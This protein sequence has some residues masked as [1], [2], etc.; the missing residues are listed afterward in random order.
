MAPSIENTN[1]NTLYQDA[2]TG[3]KDSKDTIVDLAPQSDGHANG[4]ESKV[5]W[6]G[7][8]DNAV[9]REQAVLSYNPNPNRSVM[10]M[11]SMAGKVGAVTGGTRGIGYAA[12]EALAEAGCHV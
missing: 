1:A 4:H 3:E 10:D 6:D 11:F 2:S 5:R 12:A 7:L 8:I 9:T